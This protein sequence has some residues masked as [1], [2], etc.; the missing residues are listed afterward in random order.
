M[1]NLTQEEIQILTGHTHQ[2][3]FYDNH[4]ETFDTIRKSP[5]P[6]DYLPIG[7]VY[8]CECG[9]REIRFIVWLGKHDRRGQQ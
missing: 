9:A 4:N 6:R 7:T 8:E 2:F 1:A 5:L 3:K